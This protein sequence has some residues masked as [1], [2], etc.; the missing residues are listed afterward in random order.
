MRLRGGHAN[1]RDTHVHAAFSPCMRYLAS[2]SEDPRAALYDLRTGAA[3]PRAFG[4]TTRR[5]ATSGAGA[6]A[7]AGAAEVGRG[8]PHRD[9]AVAVAFNPLY[10]QVASGAYD[11]TINFFTSDRSAESAQ[12]TAAEWG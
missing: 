3:H 11:G 4:G 2:G 1:K 10:P 6:G 9:A 7:G 5:A 8:R 12:G